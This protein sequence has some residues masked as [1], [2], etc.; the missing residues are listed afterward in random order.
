MDQPF[1]KVDLPFLK[2]HLQIPQG[3]YH[4]SQGCTYQLLGGYQGK[5]R[6]GPTIS[7]CG[8]NIHKN[9]IK[10]HKAVP[11]SSPMVIR[12]IPRL[13]LPFLRVG[14]P[15][16]Q[17]FYQQSQGGTYQILSCYQGEPKDRRWT[18][19]SLKWTR[20]FHND[21]ISNLKAAPSSSR[22]GPAIPKGGPTNPQKMFITNLKAAP[23]SFS[24]VIREL[25]MVDLPFLKADLPTS[26]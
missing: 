10:D 23:A 21:S 8:R 6:G 13:H 26:E 7:K 14:L 9:G 22:C 17:G 3:F 1:V 11:T 4:K 16:P 15:I 25:P 20:R 24:L 19:H 5:P 2:V 12:E 18:Y